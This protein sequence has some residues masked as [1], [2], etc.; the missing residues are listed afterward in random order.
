M[1]NDSSSLVIM[2]IYPFSPVLTHLAIYVV[3]VVLS[4]KK[5]VRV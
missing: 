3:Y 4:V 1:K 5:G 2:V